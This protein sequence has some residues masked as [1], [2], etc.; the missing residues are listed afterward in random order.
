MKEMCTITCKD[1]AVRYIIDAEGQR[2]VA[3]G[4]SQFP[5]DLRKKVTAV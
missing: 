2:E 5:F 1:S 4:N 3:S